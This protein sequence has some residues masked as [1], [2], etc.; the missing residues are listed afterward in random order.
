MRGYSLIELIVVISI[1]GI[2]AVVT[3]TSYQAVL[4]TGDA[5]HAALIYVD[6]LRE[7]QNRARLMEFDTAWGAT[8]LNNSNVVVFSGATYATRT[9]A[10]DKTYVLPSGVTATGATTT[11]FAKFTGNAASVSTT[12]FANR[13]ATTT[14]T[15]TSGGGVEFKP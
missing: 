4:K 8:I 11:L 2:L 12:T 5:K 6:A 13:Y 15:I 1:I 9:A 14:V 7:A 3:T 10:R